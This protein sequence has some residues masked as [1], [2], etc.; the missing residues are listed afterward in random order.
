MNKYIRN[1]SNYKFKKNYI[2]NPKRYHFN[3]NR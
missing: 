3:E 1:V 2:K